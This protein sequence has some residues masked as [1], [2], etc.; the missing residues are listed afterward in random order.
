MSKNFN[1]ILFIFQFLLFSL[2][3]FAIPRNFFLLLHLGL[4][5]NFLPIF[6]FV[7]LYVTLILEI[8]V[9]EYSVTM[10]DEKK[11]SSSFVKIGDRQLFTVELR[12][13]ET[14][15]VSWKKLLKDAAKSNGSASTSQH[16]RPE[17]FPVRFLRFHCASFWI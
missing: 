17:T 9:S 1:F 7:F 5:L 8:A 3:N 14:T 2:I 16:S 6:N 15:I 13:G 12:P 4:I 11:P 10:N